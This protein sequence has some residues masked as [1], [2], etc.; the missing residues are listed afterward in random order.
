MGFLFRF[1]TNLGLYT[2]L[3]HNFLLKKVREKFSRLKNHPS[4]KYILF[5][6]QIKRYKNQW[7]VMEQYLL[8]III[9]WITFIS[10]VI[11]KRILVEDISSQII[12]INTYNYSWFTVD[13]LKK[14]SMWNLVKMSFKSKK[15]F[16]GLTSK[17]LLLLP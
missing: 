11:S 5:I 4:P 6:S 10:I 16:Y 1:W 14:C 12:I 8:F 17:N 2:N 9:F 3:H 15:F 7:K 13:W